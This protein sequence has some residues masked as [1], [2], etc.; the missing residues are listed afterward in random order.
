VVIIDDAGAMNADAQN[1]LLKTLEEPPQRTVLV[2]CCLHPGQL[3]A[4][5]RS[6]C[7]KLSL[8]PVPVEQLEPWLLE[9]HAAAPELAKRAAA[10]ARG[11]PGRAITLLDP[12]LDEA[13]NERVRTLI[14]CTEGKRE[15]IDAVL[16]GVQRNREE[17]RIT[18]ELLEELLRDA[19]LRSTGA[20]VRPFHDSFAVSS[21]PL[22]EL[23]PARLAEIVDHVESAK[24]RL[25]RNVDPGALV[26]DVLLRLHGV[27]S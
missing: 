1:K 14:G 10:G 4:T 3:L 13:Q 16:S 21:G 24:E 25:H 15:D 23:S 26:E 2:L 5:V 11:L 22:T 20:R 12:E 6:R 18:L 27:I 7:Q 19:A 17:S 8:G 9:S